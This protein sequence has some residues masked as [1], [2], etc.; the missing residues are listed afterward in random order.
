MKSS[1]SAN[2]RLFQRTP[3]ANTGIGEGRDATN[4][5]RMGVERGYP[6]PLVI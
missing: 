4:G 5:C 2:F 1:L 3:H 6:K